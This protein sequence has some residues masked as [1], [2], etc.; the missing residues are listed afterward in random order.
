MKFPRNTLAA[1][2]LVSLA[3][4]AAGCGSSGSGSASGSSAGSPTTS[5]SAGSGGSSSA[6]AAIGTRKTSLGTVLVNS[7]GLTLYWFANDSTSASTCTGACASAW[8]PVIGTPHPASGVTLSGKFGTIKRPDGSLEATYDG[9]PLYTF[10]GDT[11]AGQVTG[12]ALNNSAASGT[13]PTRPCRS[14]PRRR[15]AA[16]AEAAVTATEPSSRQIP[17][18]AHRR[19]VLAVADIPYLWVAYK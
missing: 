19:S 13:R 14:S 5:T 8:P 12:N 3:L 1:A 18:T 6:T 9:H 2:G 15:R 7:S 10:A 17:G 16:A 11:A 4:L